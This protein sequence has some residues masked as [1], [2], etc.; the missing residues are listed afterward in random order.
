[1]KKRIGLVGYGFISGKGHV[2]A[3]AKRDDVE[4]VA[5]ADICEARRDLARQALPQAKIYSTYRELLAGEKNLDILDIASP[6][7]VHAEI[8][9]A[10][11]EKG[12]HVL[13]EKPLA[14]STE[15]ARA[16]L[17][18]AEKN[19]RVLFPCHNYKHAPVVKL[20]QE[21]IDSGR[22]GAVKSV[23][24]Q[25]FR[26]TH[27]KG[28][29]EWRTDWRRDFA[30]SGGGIGMDHGSHTFYLT[31]SWL[32][33]L[34]IWL[35]AKALNLSTEWDTEDNLTATVEFPGKRYAHSYLSWT[36]GMRKVIY[37][38]Q[39]EKGGIV[40]NDDD[41][42]ISVGFPNTGSHAGTGDHKVEKFTIESDWMDASHTK[43]FNSM[44]DKFLGCIA[45]NDFVNDEIR[46]SYA[47]V[48]IIEKCYR[49]SEQNSAGLKLET[50]YT[51]V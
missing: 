47:C 39:G 34:P 51:H 35:S 1:M 15:Q 46:E 38:I 37:T 29:K 28:V 50:D 18:A 32:K 23:T 2:P 44:F 33:S 25:T 45:K 3:F 10:A 21:V 40:V 13:C 17:S 5:V 19:K 27:A 24:L 48:E 26:N 8:A 43:W 49:S 16:M 12:I 30:T 9:V 6:P 22:I 20:I 11:L 14:T 41:A 4:I 36:A 7:A 42:E 31:F